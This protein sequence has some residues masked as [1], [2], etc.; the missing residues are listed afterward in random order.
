MP[1]RDALWL[2]RLD[3]CFLLQRRMESTFS[4]SLLNTQTSRH[5]SLFKKQKKKQQ[6][7]IYSNMGPHKTTFGAV[8]KKN[9]HYSL[10]NHNN[11]KKTVIPY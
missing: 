11:K 2:S 6:Q 5:N 10:L 8:E 9:T 3:Q 1:G 7:D 4:L